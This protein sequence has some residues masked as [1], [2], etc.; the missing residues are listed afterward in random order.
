MA[1]YLDAGLGMCQNRPNPAKKSNQQST[2]FLNLH[3]QP[4]NSL[5]LQC[6]SKSDP[7]N[8]KALSSKISSEGPFGHFRHFQR[9][10]K[11]FE[12]FARLKGRNTPSIVFLDL[13][14]SGLTVRVWPRNPAFLLATFFAGQ[15]VP[16]CG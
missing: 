15:G 14:E 13:P 5:F 3:L 8:A 6:F 9:K 12:C 11:H 7:T 4:S 1:R 10:F 2:H 16:E